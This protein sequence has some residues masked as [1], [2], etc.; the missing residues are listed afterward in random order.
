MMELKSLISRILHDFYLEPIDL[1]SD[2]K[3]MADI[4]LRPI[5][6]VKIKLVRII[7]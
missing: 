7:K 3:L 2:M 5:D 6:S 1:T 4:I